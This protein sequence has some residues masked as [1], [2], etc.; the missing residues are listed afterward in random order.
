MTYRDFINIFFTDI[1][2][3]TSSENDEFFD[4]TLTAS[5]LVISNKSEID[6]ALLFLQSTD[7]LTFTI[8]FDETDPVLFYSNSTD[9]QS[10][11]DKLIKENQYL[12]EGGQIR[13]EFKIR[14]KKVDDII[15]IYDLDIFSKTL[16]SLKTSEVFAIFNRVFTNSE[17]INFKVAGLDV[18]FQ[19]NTIYFSPI[20]SEKYVSDSLGRLSRIKKMAS[21]CYFAGVKGHQ[22][23]PDDFKVQGSIPTSFSFM[24]NKYE[25]ILSA[26]FLFDITDLNEDTFIF[27]INGYKS[28][29]GSIDTSQQF[30]YSPDYFSIYNWVYNGGNLFDKI[31]LARNIISLH[32]VKSG[33]L[34]LQ[35]NSYQS[36]KSNFNV[37]EKQN[38]K[39][40]I[41]I[42]NKVSDQLLD[43][44]NRANK[45]IE[46]FGSGF[47]KSA[48]A[49]VTYY[50]STIVLRVLGSGSYTNIFTFDATVLAM[51]FLIVSF[52]YFLIARWEVN[53]QR[54]RFK[55][56]YSNL[57]ERYTDLL[58]NAD[59]NKIL[60]N[61]KEFNADVEFI[62]NKLRKYSVMWIGFLFFLL[63]G[64]LLLFITYNVSQL[65][66]T[67]IWRFLFSTQGCS[68]N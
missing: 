23:L 36:V 38:I 8:V 11:L 49:L 39:Q 7:E 54:K 32:F 65:L 43:F 25:N 42:R 29:N 3:Q 50:A 41:E 62:T 10:F 56:S 44:N 64:T 58:D 20:Q 18:P 59:I 67:P 5:N 60:N 13:I 66:D 55:D 27:R 4:M 46:T 34:T 33:E 68:S 37:Y 1:A 15:T 30:D 35:D 28:I 21:V 9:L 22:L 57:K 12:V 52:V 40:Y 31:G 48:L 63:I 16:E 14:K 19:T 2:E 24:F 17:Y 45:I 6:E 53:V 26:I 61:D 47:Q 51:I